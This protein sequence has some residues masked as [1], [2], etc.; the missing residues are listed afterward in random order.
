MLPTSALLTNTWFNWQVFAH[1]MWADLGFAT[2]HPSLRPEDVSKLKVQDHPPTAKL[3]ALLHNSPPADSVI[4]RTWFQA[5]GTRVSSMSVRAI[6]TF[7]YLPCCRFLISGIDKIICDVVRTSTR[8]ITGRYPQRKAT[9]AYDGT[10]PMLLQGRLKCP[11][12]F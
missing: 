5:M 9:G 4:A 7:L 2:V 12:A 1:A 6:R 3:V 10:E 11:S 8:S